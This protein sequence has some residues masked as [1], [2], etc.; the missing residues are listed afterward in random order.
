VE[1]LGGALAAAGHAVELI[2]I[3]FKWYPIPFL[4]QHALLW[5]QLDLT[6]SNGVPIDLVIGT[7]FPSYLVK[8]PNKVVWLIHQHREAYDLYDH[9]YSDFRD[10][11]PEH[12]AA[13]QAILNMDTVALGE[14]RKVYTIS[15]NVSRR[16]KQYNDLDSTPLYPPS[17]YTD[18]LRSRAY[19]DYVL[20]VGR[21]DPKKRIRLLVE[22]VKYMERGV[23]VVICGTGNILPELQELAR[24]EG[25]AG[26]IRFT[27]YVS[28]EAVCEYYAHA[29]CVVYAPLDED[30][31]YATIEAFLSRRPVIT[32][33]DAGGV[34]EFVKDGHNGY[35]I[36]RDA[37][38]L[39]RRVNTLHADRALCR[40]MGD[41]GH[42]Q[43]AWIRWPNVL[44]DLLH[45]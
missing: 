43:V 37:K 27:G 1:S 26:R 15:W 11:N 40:R 32:T 34:L 2:R 23:S 42:D 38:Q 12:R 19:G 24:A 6:E 9:R 16:L 44:E 10:D 4:L 30:Y 3:P 35:V 22:S 39:A 41:A 5:R 45:A 28:D 20:F 31:G 36:P 29:L 33:E 21:L 8:H 25:V 13:R 17:K 7:K 14:A 18:R